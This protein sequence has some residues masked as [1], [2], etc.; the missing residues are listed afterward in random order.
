MVKRKSNKLFKSL[1]RPTKFAVAKRRRSLPKRVRKLERVQRL[2]APET[3]V[4]YSVGGFAN[5]PPIALASAGAILMPAVAQGL[6]DVTRIGDS[7]TITSYKLVMTVFSNI[8]RPDAARVRLIVVQQK[9]IPLVALQTPTLGDILAVDDI[10]SPKRPWRD[11]AGYHIITD[12]TMAIQHGALTTDY[13]SNTRFIARTMRSMHINLKI[14]Q[15]KIE[16]VAAS[17]TILKSGQL[18]YW[19]VCDNHMNAPDHTLLETLRFID[20]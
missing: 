16:Y 14:K 10:A 2:R 17:S 1:H 8:L 12:R 20:T 4:I 15:R 18:Y 5:V 11:R 3:K 19:L 9:M 7:I 6:T 13:D